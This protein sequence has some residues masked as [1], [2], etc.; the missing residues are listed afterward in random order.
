MRSDICLLNAFSVQ[1]VKEMLKNNLSDAGKMTTLR[2]ISSK[3]HVTQQNSSAKNQFKYFLCKAE[4]KA[5]IP[6]VMSEE[7]LGHNKKKTI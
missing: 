5:K 6:L 3:P 1:D 7:F 4:T 2:K